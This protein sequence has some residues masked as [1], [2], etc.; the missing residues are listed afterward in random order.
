MLGSPRLQA[1]VPP[2]GPSAAGG[3]GK[4][5]N[6]RQTNVSINHSIKMVG[7]KHPPPATCFLGLDAAFQ[8]HLSTPH[9]G[10]A[11]GLRCQ[12][13][14]L[15]AWPCGPPWSGS[16]CADFAICTMGTAIALPPWPRGHAVK[17]LHTQLRVCGPRC[18]LSSMSAPPPFP[19]RGL[20]SHWTQLPR[21][22]STGEQALAFL[23]L[24][25][26]PGLLFHVPRR[27]WA[28]HRASW[29]RHEPPR[30]SPGSHTC[31]P[32]AGGTAV[33]QPSTA[34]PCENRL[35]GEPPCPGPA[36]PADSL[37]HA[38]LQASPL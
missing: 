34:S 2:V 15:H 36:L 32:A 9:S 27:D 26:K 12:T 23:P 37:S 18:Q 1:A 14:G 10:S 35:A 20:E 7:N 6:R 22:W 13:L 33:T 28:V 8:H 17:P 19:S 31:F 3:T 38:L 11:C 5:Q 30:P 16:C 21:P 29:C 25:H 4:K 24:L